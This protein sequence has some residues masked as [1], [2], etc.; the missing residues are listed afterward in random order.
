MNLHTSAASRPLPTGVELLRDPALNKGTAFTHA[1]RDA[2]GL[3]G[4]LPPRVTSEQLQAMR[5]LENLR[6]NADPL[7][8]YVYLAELH[9][10]NEALFFRTVID[11]LEETLPI[12]YTPTVGLAC[13]RYGHI[14]QRPRGLFVSA[15]DRGHVARCCA[16]GRTATSPSSS[17]PTA[18][19]S[20][21]W[22]TSARTEWASRWASSPCTRR[23]R[24]CIRRA[25][26]RY[27]STWEPTARRCAP[28]RST[29]ACRNRA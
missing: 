26:C 8:K 14:F 2:L 9:E 21:A 28:T 11:N 12:I 5:V 20:W 18:S 6:A 15:Q 24:E 1:E 10:R 19:A 13:Q 25:A 27:C 4:L 23:A 29:W 16:T 3:R 7:A 17:C 22:A